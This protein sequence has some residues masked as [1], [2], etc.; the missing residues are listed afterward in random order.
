[1]KRDESCPQ[2]PERGNAPSMPSTSTDLKG[3]EVRTKVQGATQ[4]MQCSMTRGGATSSQTLAE[5]ALQATLAEMPHVLPFE[6]LAAYSGSW[7]ESDHCAAVFGC[8][9]RTES[10][11]YTQPSLPI[12]WRSPLQQKGHREVLHSSGR[13]AGVPWSLGP[14]CLD[15][16]LFLLQVRAVRP[17]IASHKMTWLAQTKDESFPFGNIYEPCRFPRPIE[18]FLAELKGWFGWPVLHSGTGCP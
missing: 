15:L 9:G 8:F 13:K 10:P 14:V 4:C 11:F 12:R 7:V 16:S 18:E 17:K 6:E 5:R 3:S 1:M 2:E